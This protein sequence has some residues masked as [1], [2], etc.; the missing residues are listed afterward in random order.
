LPLLEKNIRNKVWKHIRDYCFQKNIF[1]KNI[2]GST[3]HAH[4]L[5]LLGR[6]QSISDVMKYIKGESSNWINKNK[7]TREYFIW[8]E[9]YWAAS[10]S[11][12]D[13]ERVNAYIDNQERHHSEKDFSQELKELINEFGLE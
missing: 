5:I 9:D 4:C 2:N 8:Q 12:K 7:I 3:D 10:V 6:T 1:L 13:L 11:D